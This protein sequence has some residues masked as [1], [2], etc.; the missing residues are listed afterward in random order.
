MYGAISGFFSKRFSNGG[1]Q[2][3]F[4]GLSNL[5]MAM[6]VYFYWPVQTTQSQQRQAAERHTDAK[7]LSVQKQQS[8]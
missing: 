6:L 7:Q 1:V 8:F 2:F 4:W 5:Y 3:L